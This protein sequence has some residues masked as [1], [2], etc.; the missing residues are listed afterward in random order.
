MKKGLHTELSGLLREEARPLHPAAGPSEPGGV[1]CAVRLPAP[2]LELLTVERS[3]HPDERTVSK[4]Q[5]A[6]AGTSPWGGSRWT[7]MPAASTREPDALRIPPHHPVGALAHGDG[8]LGVLPKGETG[9]AQHRG[10]ILHATQVRQHH[11]SARLQGDEVQVAEGV[12]E[13]DAVWHNQAG[14]ALRVRGWTGKIT[15]R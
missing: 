6:V 3:V 11:R 7:T 14:H 9:H 8:A 2:A 15:G 13:A 12:H 5:L 4:P 10:L 1:G